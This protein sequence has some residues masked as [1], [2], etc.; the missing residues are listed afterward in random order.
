[1]SLE[2]VQ[3]IEGSNYEKY[4]SAGGFLNEKDYAEVL[5]QVKDRKTVDS[6]N[7]EQAQI[8]ASVA[9]IELQ[10]SGIQIDPRAALY[11]VL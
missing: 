5:A 6:H 8:M 3:D 11:D 4:K 1:M 10:D 7:L 9:G 2:Y